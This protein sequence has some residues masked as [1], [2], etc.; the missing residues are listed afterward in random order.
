MYFIY[1][2]LMGLAALLLTPYW[3]VK[4]LRHSKYF[5]N[6]KQ[7]LGFSF[8]ALAKLPADRLQLERDQAVA[9][10]SGEKADIRRNLPCCAHRS[11]HRAQ[12]GTCFD[13]PET[14]K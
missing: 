5:S 11:R 4:G 9:F 6:L 12:A 2:L 13:F 1:S 14:G 8:P 7:R 10:V 3:V